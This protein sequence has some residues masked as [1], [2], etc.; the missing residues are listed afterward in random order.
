MDQ[1]DMQKIEPV[2]EMTPIT[3]TEELGAK[4]AFSLPELMAI[5]W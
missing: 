2:P 3:G 4:G 5:N 1:Q